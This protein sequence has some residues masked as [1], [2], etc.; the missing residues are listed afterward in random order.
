MSLRADS[1]I[2]PQIAYAGEI[3]HGKTS[4]VQHDALGIFHGLPPLLPSTRYH[5]LSANILTLPPLLQVSATTSESGVIMGIRHRK[6]TIEAVQYHPESVLS[7]GGRE[8]L[9]NFL[10]LRGGEWGGVNAWCGITQA[11]ED[12]KSL[13]IA[14][15]SSNGVPPA[16]SIPTI[17][18]SIHQQR[19]VDI[20]AS[21]SIPAT[22]PAN[23][24]RSIALHAAPP[25]MPLVARLTQTLPSHPAV[26]AEIKRASPSKGDISPLTNA[27]EQA[28]RYALAGASVISVLTEP[29]WFKGALSDLLAVRTALASLPNRPALLRKDFILSTYQIDEARIHGADT[30]LL[31][32]A[33]LDLATLRKLYAY[34]CSLGMEPLVEVNNAEELG[35]ALDVGSK[36]IGVNNRNLHDFK[37]DMQ[38][39]S[40]LADVL[41]ERG[42]EDV[43]LCALSGIS[44]RSDVERYVGEGVS[45]VLV[46]EALMRS[47]D[48]R[49]FIKHLLGLPADAEKEQTKRK[50]LVKICG[51]QTLEDAQAA[52]NAGAD[53]IGLIFAP[54]RRQIQPK[55]ARKIATY[56][57]NRRY[58]DEDLTFEGLT[59]ADP[60]S[61]Q[62]WFTSS[63]TRVVSST[64]PL[65]VGVFQN[66]PL[67]YIQAVA[68]AVPLDVVQLHGNE[69]AEWAAQ[70][71]VPVIK[72]FHVTENGSIRGGQVDRPGCNE[73]ILLDAAGQQAGTTGG[74]EGRSFD[75]SVAADI[76]KRGESGSNGRFELPIILAGGLNPDN[77]SQAVAAVRPWCV[78]VSSGVEN[79]DGKT[80]DASRIAEFIKRAKAA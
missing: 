50:P 12:G 59:A 70:I 30:V 4:L 23:L 63:T 73:L 31:I 55:I 35:I 40:R 22:T 77:V 36:V 60:L 5:S 42:R 80:K 74:G 76:V 69:P 51:I 75:W 25:V 27:P 41:R 14:N 58:A 57:R 39:T 46:G 48:P 17:L 72:A 68:A 24:Q 67:A 1:A 79:A 53:M 10:K 19:L 54:T 20:A 29:K 71:P 61:P 49:V 8:I 15:G 7:E 13:D 21:E 65:L 6:F 33:M 43:V 3:L 34:S 11:E 45:A 2:L 44:S 38:T 16:P 66:Q 47:D 37:V 62:P 56:L 18:N 9:G 26:M 64:K 28:M 52:E 32:V 78:D